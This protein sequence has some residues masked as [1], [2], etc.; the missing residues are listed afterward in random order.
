MT[1]MWKSKMGPARFRNVAFH[2][3]GH[4][5]GSPRRVAVHEY[6]GRDMPFGEDLGAAAAEFTLRVIWSA[7]TC[8]L[9]AARR[10]LLRLWCR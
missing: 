10:R 7:I 3:S 8:Q 6:P 9:G 5:R 4:T 2:L 1:A